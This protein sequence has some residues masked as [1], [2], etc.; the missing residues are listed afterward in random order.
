M[1]QPC[2]EDEVMDNL[3]YMKIG[4]TFDYWKY[5]RI[6]DESVNLP[7]ELVAGKRIGIWIN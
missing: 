4:H 7:P 6:K 1:E 5:L 2:L 3:K